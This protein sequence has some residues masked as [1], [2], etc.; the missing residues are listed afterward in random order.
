MPAPKGNQYAKGHGCGRPRTVCPDDEELI[1]LGEELVNWCNTEPT[2]NKL[3]ITQWWSGEKFIRSNVWEM[4][5]R[6]NDFGGYYEKALRIL[7]IK[8]IDG[9]INA[10]IAG[11]FLRLYFADLRASDDEL[12]KLK[13]ELAKSQDQ[14]ADA[15]NVIRKLAQVVK[16]AEEKDNE[17]A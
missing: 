12:L 10:T 9:T 13:A 11:R 2:S 17:C 6:K 14:Q 16:S 3:H 8:Y 4:M 15:E 5:I 1:K 7:A